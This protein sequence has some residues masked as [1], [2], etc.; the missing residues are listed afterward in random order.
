MWSLFLIPI[1]GGLYGLS[2]HTLGDGH[3]MK[4]KYMDVAEGIT[5]T[6]HE[7]YDRTE[8]KLGPESFRFTDTSEAKSLKS[9][10]KYYILRPE[11]IESYFI[12]WRLTHNQK[13]REWGW[14]AVQVST[15]VTHFHSSVL[16]LKNFI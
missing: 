5:N 3:S 12:M 14:E 4:N 15:G 2:S 9:S 13:Y 1:L 6:C 16:F 11:V 7:S 8:T 10:E